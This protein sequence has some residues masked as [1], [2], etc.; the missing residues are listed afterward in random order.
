MGAAFPGEA[1]RACAGSERC[2]RF[3][4]ENCQKIEIEGKLLL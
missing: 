1:F 3:E 2:A 4:G